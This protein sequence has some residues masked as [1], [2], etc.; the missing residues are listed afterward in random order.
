VLHCLIAIQILS[1]S[2]DRN[3][4]LCF[5]RKMHLAVPRGQQLTCAL[6]FADFEVDTIDYF[7]ALAGLG[8]K[9]DPDAYLLPIEIDTPRF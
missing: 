2:S 4:R 6:L 7:T 8:A 1:I 3:E 5:A 9:F